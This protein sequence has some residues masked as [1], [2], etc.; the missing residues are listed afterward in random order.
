[1]LDDLE[2]KLDLNR[3]RCSI[4]LEL[5]VLEYREIC[6]F[7]FIDALAVST[8]SLLVLLHGYVP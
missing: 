5:F 7:L 4:H 6:A 1:M 8:S 3:E 2:V